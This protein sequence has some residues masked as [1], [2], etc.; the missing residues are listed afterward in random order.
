MSN[1]MPQILEAL[2]RRFDDRLVRVRIETEHRD[3]KLAYEID[4]RQ[5]PR[6]PTTEAEDTDLRSN[7]P[8]PGWLSSSADEYLSSPESRDRSAHRPGNF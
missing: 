3:L 1:Q 5:T 7:G 6:P 8:M 4:I 2:L